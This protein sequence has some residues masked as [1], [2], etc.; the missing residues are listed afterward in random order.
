MKPRT[1]TYLSPPPHT[2]FR[3]FLH[4]ECI[5]HFYS[6][7][8]AVSAF[9][10]CGRRNLLI[11]SLFFIYFISTESLLLISSRNVFESTFFLFSRL[12]SRYRSPV[13]S[14]F[15]C[16]NRSL[17]KLVGK[18]HKLVVTVKL[19]SFSQSTAPCKDSCNGVCRCFFTL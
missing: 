16:L 19:A 18:S 12:E 14:V 17:F 4:D 11:I 9:Y 3:I 8:A 2:V 6:E 13:N 15:N 1:L 5:L 10:G 7:Y